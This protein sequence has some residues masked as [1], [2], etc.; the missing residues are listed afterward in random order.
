MVAG[1]QFA[2]GLSHIERTAI[3]L[4][5]ACDEE[6]D[7]GDDGRNV[8][9]HD[10]PI[11]RASLVIDYLAHLHRTNQD[12]GGDEAE[13]ERH[14]IGNH[15][16]GSTHRRHNGI[17]V[18]TTP[19]GKEHAHHANRRN[20]RNQEQAD[21]EVEHARTLVPR[22]KRER[23]HRGNQNEER[24]QRIEEFVGLIDEENLLDEHFQHVGKH[25]KDSPRTYAHRAQTALEI[26]AD[27]SFHKN[28]CDGEQGVSRQNDDAHHYALNQ[29]R[30]E[31]AETQS[32]PK[33]TV[34]PLC[35]YRKIKHNLKKL[36]VNIRNHD[37]D[38]GSRRHEVGNFLTAQHRVE[39]S[40]KGQTHRAQLQ[41]I[42]ALVATGIE[43]DTKLTG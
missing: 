21:V 8:T 26:G 16:H 31:I 20:G 28:Q 41:S 25:L 37:V 23:A 42:R 39:R 2:L 40:H 13:A 27:L 6:H 30:P 36:S 11:P 43:I 14:L 12:D 15:L 22:Q 33:K 4:G 10:E 18:V 17:F 35:Y 1:S 34:E 19:S 29:Y 9:A 7:E 38:G 32:F 5:I 3:G 24:R